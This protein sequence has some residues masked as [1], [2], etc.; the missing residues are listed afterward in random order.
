MQPPKTE[1]LHK[2]FCCFKA[3]PARRKTDGFIASPNHGEPR[4]TA[5][6]Y[7]RHQT[8]LAN[9]HQSRVKTSIHLHQNNASEPC[10]L[11]PFAKIYWHSSKGLRQNSHPK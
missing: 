2:T 7:D 5:D 6:L 8:I 11:T 1:A 10:F 9:E 4:L 3:K